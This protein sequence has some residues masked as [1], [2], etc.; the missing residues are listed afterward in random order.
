[1]D[2]H[3]RSCGEVSTWTVDGARFEAIHEAGR[4]R[5]D[6]VDDDIVR[7]RFS[8]NG[9]FAAR[10]SWDVV[11]DHNDAVVGAGPLAG[12]Q[13]AGVIVVGNDRWQA[14]MDAV[15]GAMTFS[16]GQDRPFA[17]DLSGPRWRIVTSD[18]IGIAG[19]AEDP[20][21]VGTARTALGLVKHIAPEESHYGL[22]QRTG[23]LNRRYRRLSNWTTDMLPPGYSQ[24]HDNLYQ[25][26]PF[27]MAVRPGFAWG[28]FLH[29]SWY[30]RFDLGADN[31]EELRLCTLGGELDYY[32]FAGPTPA[33]VVEQLTRL[34][35]RPPLPP[36]WALGFHQSRWSYP[37]SAQVEA[38]AAGFR[39]R[40]IPLDAVHLDIDYMR[41]YR[42]FT[43]DPMRFARPR[44][45]VDR[46]HA[47]GVRAVCIVDPGV[48]HDV[49]GGYQVARD[50][51]ERNM[52]IRRAD[53]QLFVG[54][55][56]PG[57]ALFPDF[58]REPV[59]RWWGEQ[60]RVLLD[61]G[62]DGLWTDM[63]EP[64]IFDRPFGQ[65]GLR[66]APIPLNALQG[67]GDECTHHAEVH[68]LYG[69]LMARA[70]WEGMQRLRPGS[71]P[72]V[73][74]RS[75]FTGSQRYAVT[76]MGD[77]SSCWEHLQLSV[78]QLA[79]MGLSGMPHA[80]VDIGGFY[81]NA[82]PELY[83]RWMELGTFYPFM[84]CHTALGTRS[85]E[86]WQFGPDVEVVSRR[87]IELRY[88][89]LPYLYTLA[90][91]A[92]RTGAPLWR[93]MVYEFPDQPALHHVEDQIM[94]G[95]HL[96]VAP[97]CEPG[98]RDRLV[99]LPQ[100]RWY[101]LW[102]GRELAGGSHVQPAPLGTIPVFA[103]AGAILTLGNVRSS[104]AA[105]LTELT[106]A[107]YPAEHSQWT[108]IEDDGQSD[109]YL[110]GTLAET[111]F[112][113]TQDR[114]ETRVVIGPRRG[115]YRPRSRRLTVR[116][117]LAAPPERLTL[118]GEPL[119]DW[120][121]D[122]DQRVAVAGWTDDAGEHRLLLAHGP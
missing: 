70:T 10:R 28:L 50:G 49:S 103:R 118:D 98:A 41:G 17:Q 115:A 3:W 66:L 54:Y 24:A 113:A 43:W 53:G 20:L 107:V 19:G 18:E 7:V 83:A 93:P 65:A 96:L 45:T 30:S 79:G 81:D 21:P 77:N 69:H 31:E 117:H 94:V 72:W 90:H 11:A 80:G 34:T 95:P 13:S 56:W 46:L 109:A 89:L 105:P 61:A 92:H 52:F 63:N 14:R 55:C 110:Q 67:E 26:H 114:S 8:P 4:T 102:S 99:R 64:A 116:V 100:G 1:M 42:D 121:W 12:R 73:L 39:E 119:R 74:T 84:R 15:S 76:W 36:L 106:V 104:T 108:L 25:A 87:A 86:P 9:R 5:V 120:H 58:A 33:D 88:R 101:D 27:V 71:R 59:R 38:V 60:H 16:C 35:G 47:Q 57:E 82:H 6:A 32:L 51:I 68:N 85:Q 75:A 112:Q 40:E 78:P 22:G 97:V 91:L 2:E 44:G 122:P 29:S 48:K 111:P 37:D 62:V 23:R